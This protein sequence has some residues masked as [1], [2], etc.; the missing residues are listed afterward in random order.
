MRSRT[1]PITA[2]SPAPRGRPRRAFTLLEALIASGVLAMSVLALSSALGAGQKNS[3]EAQKMILGAIAASD[4]MS[5]LSS[6]PYANLSTYNGRNEAVGAMTTL[7]SGAYPSTYWM[8]GRRTA[9]SAETITEGS[10]SV[11]IKG[12]R[13]VVTA[14]D[15]T[16]DVAAAR[17][18]IPEP[19]P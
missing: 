6:V 19:A 12:L 11:V 3:I 14:T 4:L 7:D 9:V 17:V 18:F 5:E 13:I 16:R 2:L 1:Q 10:L 8:I 15:G